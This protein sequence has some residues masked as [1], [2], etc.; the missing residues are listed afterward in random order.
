MQTILRPSP[1]GPTRHDAITYIFFVPYFGGVVATAFGI[2]GIG[3]LFMLGA[4]FAMTTI[5]GWLILLR[6]DQ[7]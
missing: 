2:Q 3:G 5:A 1:P 7:L 4:G 6:D